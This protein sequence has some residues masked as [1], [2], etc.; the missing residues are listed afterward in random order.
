MKTVGK[1]ANKFLELSGISRTSKE[2]QIITTKIP[3]GSK[4]E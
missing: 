1:L 4:R 3:S 2:S